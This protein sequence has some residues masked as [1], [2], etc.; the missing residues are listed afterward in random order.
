MRYLDAVDGSYQVALAD[1][2]LSLTF[3]RPEHGNAILSTAVLPM[4]QLLHSAQADPLVRCLLI[5]GTGRVF[6]AGGDVVSFA[7]ALEQ[8]VDTRQQDFARRLGNIVG[9][10]EALVAFDRPVVA[11]IRGAVAG[12]GLMFPLVADY[13]IGDDSA[14]FVFAHQR[15]GLSPD[16]GVSYLL[17]Q[18]VGT[19]T[20]RT[21]LLTAAKLDAEE[22][23]RHGI[24]SR[25]FA[26]TELD[27]ESARIAQQFTRLPQR[28]AR[29]AK[30]LVNAATSNSLSVQL[31]V[32]R[33]AF[34]AC[35]GDADFAE[36]VAAFVEKRRA[37]FPSTRAPSPQ[38]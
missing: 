34:V 12:A 4:S 30:Q 35:V 36:G 28:A 16:C 25:I 22:A 21:L 26:A 15:V 9:L 10:V 23:L 13:A 17:P 8:D 29:L 1:G 5:K 27:L 3:N 2:V 11:V 38:T 24:L 18:V 20:A 32:E 6:C 7:S 19:R 14:K 37:D 31:Q 33:A